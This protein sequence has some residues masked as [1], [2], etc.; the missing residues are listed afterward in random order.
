MTKLTSDEADFLWLLLDSITDDQLTELVI[1]DPE[2]KI[3]LDRLAAKLEEGI[4]GVEKYP[5]YEPDPTRFQRRVKRLA[6]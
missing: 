6:F 2:N 5:G 3:D 4:G 1:S